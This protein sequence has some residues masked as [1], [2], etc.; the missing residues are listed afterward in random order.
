MKPVAY[1]YLIGWTKQKC[2]PTHIVEKWE[3]EMLCL[4]IILTDVSISDRW[5]MR[6]PPPYEIGLRQL[7]RAYESR[8]E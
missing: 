2:T 1:T 5:S 3:K 6:E 7:E 8:D 4:N